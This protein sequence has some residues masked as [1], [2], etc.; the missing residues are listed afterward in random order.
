MNETIFKELPKDITNIILQYDGRIVCRNGKYINR[1]INPDTAF[2]QLFERMK[3]DKKRSIIGGCFCVHIPIIIT[4][5]ILAQ[6]IGVI[7][8]E[9]YYSGTKYGLSIEVVFSKDDQYAWWHRRL[10]SN[11]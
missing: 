4:N 3:F 5:P 7:Q 11:N 8:K 10:Y 1:I 6:K 9:F 2:P